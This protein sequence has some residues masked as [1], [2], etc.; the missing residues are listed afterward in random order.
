VTVFY[1][2]S[3]FSDLRYIK[4][5]LSSTTV[6]YIAPCIFHA[7]VIIYLP[8]TENGNPEGVLSEP[9]QILHP[10]TTL[11][12][13]CSLLNFYIFSYKRKDF[14]ISIK[15]STIATNRVRITY[16]MSYDS[17]SMLTCK[18]FVLMIL[19]LKL[20]LQQ[21]SHSLSTWCCYTPVYSPI[22]EY[23]WT[24]TSTGISTAHRINLWQKIVKARIL[25]TFGW[26]GSFEHFCLL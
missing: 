16:K 5:W 8:K 26:V 19:H 20:F 14:N 24:Y 23:Y 2:Y 17:R 1:S 12:N 21:I 15:L 18:D 9:L 25:A 13:M 3:V 22:D 11:A 7:L 10:C 4:V 6:P